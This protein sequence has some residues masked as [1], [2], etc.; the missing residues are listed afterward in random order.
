MN[1]LLFVSILIL[2]L[3]WGCKKESKPDYASLLPGKW[4]NTQVDNKPVLTDDTFVVEYRSDLVE[5]YAKGFILDSNNRSWIVNDKYTYIVNGDLIII[6]GVSDP[7]NRF[8]MEFRILYLDQE[9]LTYSVT[10]FMIDGVEYPDPKIY[11]STR[12]T[13]DLSS[14]FAGTWYG[15]STTPGATDTTH[16]YWDYFPGGHFDYYYRDNAG[17]W[18]NKPDNE[19]KYF[20]YGNFLASNY[21]NDL[22][23]GETGKSFECWNIR[24][25]GDT[26][27]WAGLRAGGQTTT[28]RMVK[29]PGPP[30]SLAN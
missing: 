14:Q 12:V 3:L 10:L 30:G 21:T 5:V 22:I 18:I 16:H 4:V 11:T 19:G 26:M 28:F 8:H 24:I 20:L 15:K 1:K 23:S 7:G 17:N 29:V 9:I 27:F 2:I 25:A 6:D 13:T